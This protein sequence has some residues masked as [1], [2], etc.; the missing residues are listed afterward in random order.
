M[1][2]YLVLLFMMLLQNSLKAEE[3]VNDEEDMAGSS[4]SFEQSR[5]SDGI[6]SSAIDLI[7]GMS[8]ESSLGLLYS[9][10]SGGFDGFGVNWN[11]SSE[12]GW[13]SWGYEFIGESGNIESHSVSAAL[14]IKRLTWSASVMPR[15][16]TILI[17]T[18]SGPKKSQT[19]TSPGLAGSYTYHTTDWDFG[20]QGGINFYNKRLDSYTSGD[21]ARFL[22]LLDPM[23][24]QLVSGLEKSYLLTSATRFYS[25]GEWGA[26]MINSI[27][28][29]DFSPSQTV[30]THIRYYL[31]PD[32]GLSLGY[33]NSRYL[34]NDSSSYSV[35]VSTYW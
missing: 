35:M 7:L 3:N 18:Q 8:K 9:T 23:A 29:I 34:Q 16:N 5:G 21:K 20:L 14:G 19:L 6:S 17:Y 10:S 12:N 13:S 24:L 32:W 27:S 31:K 11:R 30:G 15:L 2:K 4:F 25:W 26:Q 33:I 1:S 22:L 28:A